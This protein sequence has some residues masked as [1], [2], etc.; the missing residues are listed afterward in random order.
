MLSRDQSITFNSC[1]RTRDHGDES[2]HGMVSLADRKHSLGICL[3]TT[4]ICCQEFFGR[5]RAQTVYHTEHIGEKR[6]GAWLVKGTSSDPQ[7]LL[8]FC[9]HRVLRSVDRQGEPSL[10]TAK[11]RRSLNSSK[12]FHDP[13]AVACTE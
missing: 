4:P 12:E 13:I 11:S 5:L 10:P 9:I 8:T 6:S 7:F 2:F 1:S 3:Q